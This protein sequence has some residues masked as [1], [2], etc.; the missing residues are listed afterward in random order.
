MTDTTK[1]DDAEASEVT[2]LDA[3]DVDLNA[4]CWYDNRCSCGI[5]CV[6]S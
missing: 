4:D 5:E 3:A 1:L 2:R 6:P